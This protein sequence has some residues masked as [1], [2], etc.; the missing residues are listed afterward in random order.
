MS[1]YSKVNFINDND[2]NMLLIKY[3][4]ISEFDWN[5]SDYLDKILNLDIY[6]IISTNSEN[7]LNDITEYLEINKYNKLSNLQVHTEII[8]EFPEYIYELMHFVCFGE[9][10]KII[11]NEELING[12]GSLLNN[13]EDNIYNNSILIKSHIPLDSKETILCD[14]SKE[15]IKTIL[16]NR[17]NTKVV[18]FDIDEWKEINVSY[19]M[20]DY[21]NVF[22]EGE[23][24]QKMELS[25][26]LHNINIWY[27]IYDEKPNDICG[28]IVNKSIYKCIWFTMLTNEYRG[29]LTLNEVN[30]I[31]KIS[32]NKSLNEM[33]IKY[34]CDDEWLEEEEDDKGRKI[35]K[36]KYR[37]L[38]L[39]YN[40]YC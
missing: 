38:E 29:S 20:D 11:K 24:Y 36:N 14:I 16:D 28:T 10:N 1:S 17:L 9:D 32:R 5:D 4:N 3:C 25:F 7:F 6:N 22:F 19:N 2:F 35:I 31:I 34:K 27:T 13:T 18:I 12:V 21:A 8:A 40:K 15:E 23:S 37:V 39:A 30:K 33:L 26:F